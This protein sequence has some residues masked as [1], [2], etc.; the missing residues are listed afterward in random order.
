MMDMMG[1]GGSSGQMGMGMMNM[2]GGSGQMGMDMMNMGSQMGNM[3]NMGNMNMGSMNMGSMGN[4]SGMMDPNAMQGMQ[5]MYPNSMGMANHGAAATNNGLFGLGGGLDFNSLI[6]G[7][8]NFAIDIFA[9]LLLVGLIVGAAVVVKRY[10]LEGE[11]FAPR[12]KATCANCGQ[13]L[14]A[15]WQ[16][17]PKCGQSKA[18]PQTVVSPQTV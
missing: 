16:C 12:A 4:M 1:M 18:A 6:S 13:V 11:F 9:I 5:G 10:L 3:G 14:N 7:L 17:C 8:L 2:G 15:E